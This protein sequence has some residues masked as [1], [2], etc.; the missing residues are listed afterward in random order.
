MKFSL[1]TLFPEMFAG[2]LGCSIL[3]RA[4]HSGVLEVQIEN[5]RDFA[6]GRHRQVD[7]AP[8]GGGPGMVMKPDVLDAAL[9]HVTRERPGHVVHLSP[10]GRVFDQAMAAELSRRDHVVLVCGH[11]EGIDQRF[12]DARVDEELS[13]GDFVL[14]GGEIPAL[15]VVDATARLLPGVLGDADSLL[16]ES[17]Q[18][19]V[20]D[21]P[22]YTRPAG[23]VAAGVERRVPPVLLSGDHGAVARW[24]RHAAL[25]RTLARRPDL[26]DLAGLSRGERRVA[27]SLLQALAREGE[28]GLA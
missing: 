11:Y 28:D 10:Q 15:A 14:T 3:G 23:W 16:Q 25:L 20:L 26:V 13:L 12:I 21:H 24:R 8:F 17:F 27:Q 4:R 18:E 9:D 22:H 1:L 2:P 6:P 5:L 7:D 19:G